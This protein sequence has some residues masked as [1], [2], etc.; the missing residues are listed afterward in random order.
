LQIST[1][2]GKRGEKKTYERKSLD[3]GGKIRY[4]TDGGQRIK[5]KSNQGGRDVS[6]QKKLQKGGS[7]HAGAGRIGQGEKG[8]SAGV[9]VEKLIA[10]RKHNH[11]QEGG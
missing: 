1:R 11:K 6:F 10:Q 3:R 2:L 9:C 8:S 5:K 4:T 7:K